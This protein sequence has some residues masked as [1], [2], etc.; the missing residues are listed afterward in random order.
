MFLSRPLIT[1]ILSTACLFSC[2]LLPAQKVQ[3]PVLTIHFLSGA[4]HSFV[5]DSALG[6]GYDGHE[7]GQNDIILQPENIRAMQSAGL[8]PL[9]YRLRTELGIECW[10]W[11]PKGSWSGKDQG[12][13]TSSSDTSGS[14]SVS[15]GY[16]LP[17]RG[18]TG[19]Q[20]NNDGYSRIDDGDESSFWKSN[21]Y[22]DS[23]FTGESNKD[24]AQWMVIDLGRE[25]LI[26]AISIHWGKPYATEFTVDYAL[27]PVYAYF[28]NSGYYEID[29]P[30]L[31][32]PFPH[33]SFADAEGSNE[34]IRLSDKPLRARM[35]RIRMIRRTAPV[36]IHPNDD[37]RDQVGFAI[38]E[39]YIGRADKKGRM[40]V[41][42]VH[43]A[44]NNKKQSLVTVSSTDPWHRSTDIDTLTE[45]VG[46]DRLFHSGL[47]NG[48]PV[49]VP[50]GIMY[51]VPQNSLAMIG[52]LSKRHYP[53]AGIELGEEP[54]G[55]DVNPEDY[56]ALYDQWIKAI[57][58][59]YPQA[60]L[61]GPSLQ[62]LILNHLD[63]MMP[64]KKWL[65]RFLAY[66]QVHGS[67]DAFQFF[68][69]EWYPFDEACAPSAPQ[70]AAHPEMI[71]KGMH[72]LQEIPQMKNIP[73]WISEYGYSAFGGIN[74]MEIQSALMNDDIVG[75]FL[76]LGGDK[77][78]LYGMEPS[79][80]DASSECAPGNNMMFG[81]DDQGRVI[82]RTAIY[83]GAMIL[84]KYWAQPSG[85]RLRIYPVSSNVWNEQGQEL[86]SAYALLCPD[87]TWS[88]M[89]VNKDPKRAY[90]M[91]LNMEK[92]N[93]T[94]SI[95][96]PSLCYQYSGREYRW[97]VDGVKSRPLKSLPPEQKKVSNNQI[98]LPPYS[99]TVI[100]F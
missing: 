9:T 66:L 58:A 40:A 75:Q 93:K 83:Y 37:I 64:T 8:K 10:H 3:Q 95:S 76:T 99:L 41:D 18:N 39:V 22:L 35:V 43:H 59:I 44:A 28:E 53:V 26:D 17:R 23:V 25:E 38:R 45:Q 96:L 54:D 47:N 87:G 67:L 97:L 4:A 88:V 79:Q 36:R 15:Y 42:F 14:I 24:H 72:D 63:E 49:L 74:D 7:K 33:H 46:I 12:Y 82:Y 52:Y 5:P 19:D 50:T 29:S 48:M 68:S 20:A 69:F 55:Q 13:W 65:Q 27:K 71:Q 90:R 61:G 94:S 32:K 84:K 57:K 51:D 31:W 62:T 91:G 60:V 21:P 73:I 11:N 70:L 85:S 2:L 78:F 16:R 80:P 100:R 30:G 6:A 77:A 92:Q 86:V 34:T 81:M 1:L 89:I 98:E 56:G